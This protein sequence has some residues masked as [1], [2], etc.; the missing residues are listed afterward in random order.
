MIKPYLD[1]S[2]ATGYL[3]QTIPPPDSVS[4]NRYLGYLYT[5]PFSWFVYRNLAN[6]RDYRKI[7]RPDSVKPA[8]RIYRFS[9]DNPPLFGLSQGSGTVR[10]FARTGMSYWDDITAGLYLIRTGGTVAYIPNACVYHYHVKNL[11]QFVS[12]YSWRIRNN[13]T[14]QVRNMGFAS[15]RQ[16]LSS[17][18][19]FRSYLFVP[20]ALSLIFPVWDSLY[21]SLKFK[22]TVMLW[23]LPVTV[24]LALI[25]IKEIIRKTVFRMNNKLPQYE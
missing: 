13:L 22:D 14:G 8:Y 10:S 12:K 1:K 20:Y 24:I 19:N 6:P 25:M 7:Y 11:S 3:P 21:M 18:Q 23:H 9:A 15:R 2:G 4:L 17:G 16:F 5:D